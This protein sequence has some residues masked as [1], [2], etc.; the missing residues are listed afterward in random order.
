LVLLRLASDHSI[1]PLINGVEVEAKVGDVII[2]IGLRQVPNGCS[3]RTVFAKVLS[4]FRLM[5]AQRT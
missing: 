3:K 1:P 2:V 5:K 4:R